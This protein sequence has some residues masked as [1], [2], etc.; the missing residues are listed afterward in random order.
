MA[1]A[2]GTSHNFWERQNCSQSEAP[3][4]NATPLMKHYQNDVVLPESRAI[5][6]MTVRSDLYM[7]ALK[8]FGSHWLCPRLLFPKLLING[9]LLRLI[10]LKCVQNLN[11]VALAVPEIIGCTQKLGGPQTLDTPT[12]P[13]LP[14]FKRTFVRMDPV[15]VPANL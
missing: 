4:T 8:N 5:A 13:F 2:P 1:A 7:D 12:L 3:I 9:L 11:F 14:N 15:N 6:K 10:V